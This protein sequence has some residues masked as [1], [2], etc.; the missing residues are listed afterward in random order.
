MFDYLIQNG[1]LIDG[2]GAP[3]AAGD[4]AAMHAD[5]HRLA[6]SCGFVGADRLRDAVRHLMASPSDPAAMQAFVA[7]ADAV[8]AA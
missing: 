6:A 2:T 4:V 3:A 8:I 1:T 5:L 7:A